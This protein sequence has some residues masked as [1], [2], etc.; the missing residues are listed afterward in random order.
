VTAQRHFHSKAG[1]G[2]PIL[3]RGSAKR[4]FPRAWQPLNSEPAATFGH[5]LFG[6]LVVPH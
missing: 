2:S 6:T 4:V 5:F 1:P 3:E